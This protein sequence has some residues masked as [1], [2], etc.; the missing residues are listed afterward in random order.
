[1]ILS[2]LMAFFLSFNC[3]L[4]VIFSI[5]PVNVSAGDL[6]KILADFF[7]RNKKFCDCVGSCERTKTEPYCR[8]LNVAA[9]VHCG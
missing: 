3:F 8:V 4:T 2:F 1:M 7:D 5:W 6:Q 9:Y